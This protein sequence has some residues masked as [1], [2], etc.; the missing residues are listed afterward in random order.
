[1]KFIENEC[2]EDMNGKIE[3][4]E[5]CNVFNNYLKSKHLRIISPKVITKMLKEEGFEVSPRKILK[6]ADVVS[7]RCVT[8]LSLK[9]TI[10]TITTE[11][12][13]QNTRKGVTSKNCSFRSYRSSLQKV[14]NIK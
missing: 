2:K 7:V 5:F 1:M 11:I 8:N 3:I 12:S 13:S 6:G 10:T 9:T 14:E 4:R